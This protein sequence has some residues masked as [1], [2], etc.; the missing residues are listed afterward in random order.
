MTARQP[1]AE[2]SNSA[3]TLVVGQK[4]W[5][6]PSYGYRRDGHEVTVEKI[7][8]RWATLSGNCGRIDKTAVARRRPI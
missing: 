7:G 2:K 8:P 3:V 5:Y 1:C 6:V 4:L